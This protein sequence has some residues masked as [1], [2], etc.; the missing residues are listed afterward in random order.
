MPQKYLRD[1]V[2]VVMYKQ[3]RLARV[4]RKKKNNLVGYFTFLGIEALK[5]STILG[6]ISGLEYLR[7]IKRDLSFL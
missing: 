4:A 6:R 3:F 1:F 5:A 7:S 2:Q